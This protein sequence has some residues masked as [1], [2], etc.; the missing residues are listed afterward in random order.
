M[1]GVLSVF[2]HCA[3]LQLFSDPISQEKPMI[4]ISNNGQEFFP[5]VIHRFFCFNFRFWYHMRE[6]L[7]SLEPETQKCWS[8]NVRMRNWQLS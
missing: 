6:F 8:I 5:S 2:P 4:E 1:S 3:V 7:M